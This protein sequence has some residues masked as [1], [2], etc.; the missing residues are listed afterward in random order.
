[1]KDDNSTNNLDTKRYEDSDLKIKE[2]LTVSSGAYSRGG[3]IFVWNF[4]HPVCKPS[5]VQRLEINLGIDVV[6][7]SHFNCEIKAHLKEFL[8]TYC[9]SGN[10]FDFIIHKSQYYQYNLSVNWRRM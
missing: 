2:C 6:M 9:I 8:K 10:F 3:S 5:D 1:M 7:V 4:C